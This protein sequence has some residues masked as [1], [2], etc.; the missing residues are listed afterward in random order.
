MMTVCFLALTRFLGFFVS[1]CCFFYDSKSVL[2]DCKV[3]GG[4]PVGLY[5][6]YGCLYL[7]SGFPVAAI[8][9]PVQTAYICRKPLREDALWMGSLNWIV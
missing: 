3:I 4:I 8:L 9:F 5:T 7:D 2:F 6:I 1:A